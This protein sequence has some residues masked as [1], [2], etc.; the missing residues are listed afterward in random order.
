MEFLRKSHKSNNLSQ[1]NTGER[2]RNREISVCEYA[3]IQ[4]GI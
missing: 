2:K 4:I 1:T 3:Y